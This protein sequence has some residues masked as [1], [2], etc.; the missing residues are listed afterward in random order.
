[1]SDAA[2][3]QVPGAWGLQFVDHIAMLTPDLDVGSVPYTALGLTPDGPDETVTTQGVRVRA[4]RLGDTLIELLEPEAGSGLAAS[5]AKRGAGL[6]HV[7]FRV[8]SLE[9]EITRLSALGAVFLNTQPQPGRAGSRVAFLHPKWGAGTLI[10]L[11]EH[12]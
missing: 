3:V 4:F 12:A 1:M 7:A 8:A 6:H 10:E 2:P 5:L 9:A 11:V